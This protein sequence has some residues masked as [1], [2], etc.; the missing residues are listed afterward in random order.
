MHPTKVFRRQ[1]NIVNKIAFV[2]LLMTVGSS[3]KAQR[4]NSHVD[5][6]QS[7]H[8][9]MRYGLFKP[10][11]YNSTRSYPLIVYLHGSTDTVSW[12]LSWYQEA[13]QKENPC[14]VLSPKTTEPNQG[15]GNTW[16]EKHSPAMEKTLNLVDSIVKKYN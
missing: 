12:D 9:G 7:F 16:E 4:A 3:A 14:F 11:N 6:Q 2:L 13:V 1:Y 15:W 8:Q 5:Y 10:A